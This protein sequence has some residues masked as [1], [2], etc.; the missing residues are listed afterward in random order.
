VSLDQKL[1]EP[2]QKRGPTLL[3]VEI[4]RQCRYGPAF[5]REPTGGIASSR[6]QK[7]RATPGSP[8][9]RIRHPDVLAGRVSKRDERDSQ[10]VLAA[11]GQ[12]ALE[13]RQPVG[14]HQASRIR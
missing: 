6:E 11:L 13:A 3:V 2:G 12:A 5:E 9:L 10:L 1:V 8:E 4:G 7:E 14:D